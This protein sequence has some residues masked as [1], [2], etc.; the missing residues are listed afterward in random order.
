MYIIFLVS[1]S[2]SV[3]KI[4]AERNE[5]ERNGQRIRNQRGPDWYPEHFGQKR[6]WSVFRPT[7]GGVLQLFSD[8]IFFINFM[9]QLRC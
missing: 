3:Q 7:Q 5:I 2:L 6:A 9:L 4:A 1:V 8:K